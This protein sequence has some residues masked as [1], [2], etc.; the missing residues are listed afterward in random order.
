MHIKRL[1]LEGWQ[2]LAVEQ[3]KAGDRGSLRRTGLFKVEGRKEA[4]VKL[5]H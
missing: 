2:V 4:S 1:N 5:L 3:L